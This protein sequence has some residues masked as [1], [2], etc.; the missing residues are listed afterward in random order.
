M[1]RII[2]ALTLPSALDDFTDYFDTVKTSKSLSSPYFQTMNY[3]SKQGNYNSTVL[4]MPST[5]TKATDK[6]IIKWWESSNPALTAFS[7]KRSFFNN[8]YI[9]FPNTDKKPRVDLIKNLI[10]LNTLYSTSSAYLEVKEKVIKGLGDN[11]IKYIFSSYE[12]LSFSDVEEVKEIYKNPP[13]FVYKI[14]N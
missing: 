3:L 6:S 1:F 13:Y 9:E 8:Q 14:Q 5:N 11:N 12:V 2:I 10:T 7:N 4:E